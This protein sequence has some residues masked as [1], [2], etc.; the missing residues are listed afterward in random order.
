MN[1][2]GFFDILTVDDRSE[3]YLTC[4]AAALLTLGSI[5]FSDHSRTW[6]T[7][8]IRKPGSLQHVQNIHC[9][10]WSFNVDYILETWCLLPNYFSN[11]NY[12]L[13]IIIIL[14]IKLMKNYQLTYSLK[15]W[16]F[17]F[18]FRLT[19]WPR[20]FWKKWHIK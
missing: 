4:A 10:S 3:G 11:K 12:Q 13:L 17:F 15:F 19:L 16:F 5:Q 9:R 20:R 6:C 1:V 8:R 2:S 14:K 7:S 18:N